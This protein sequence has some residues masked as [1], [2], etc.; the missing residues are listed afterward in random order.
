MVLKVQFWSLTPV[1]QRSEMD[2]AQTAVSYRLSDPLEHEE[3]GMFMLR[4]WDNA[5][6]V[7]S[8][9]LEQFWRIRKLCLVM[10]YYRDH[11]GQAPG[12]SLSSFSSCNVV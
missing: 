6:K 5:T 9:L 7:C 8:I 12:G 4:V 11:K 2:G 3:V 10:S 1:P